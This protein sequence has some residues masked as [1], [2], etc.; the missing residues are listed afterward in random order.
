VPKQVILRGLG[1]S[2]VNAGVP[3]G[4][5]LNDPVLE[6]HGASGALITSNDNWKDS[7]ERA[8]FE[9]T[10]FQPT[11][12]RE[13]V[14]L[15]TLPPASYTAVLKGAANSTGV[16][17]VE[18]YDLDQSSDSTLTNI[19]SRALVETG[20]NVVIAGFTLG[21]PNGRPQIIIRGLGPSL[22]A[23][24]IANPLANPTL[25]LRDANAALLAANDNWKDDPFQSSQ[26]TAAGLQPQNDLESAIAAAL[27]PGAFTAIVAGKNGG[28]G[29]GLVEVYNL[30]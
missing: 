27:P 9:G 10:A 29:V 1:P 20:N 19:S 25:E 17:T 24:G 21:G 22:A 30:Q 6:L 12:D 5:V 11:D 3:A 18:V 28:T 7:P 8:Q 16:G 14:I 23:F 13:A 26:V 4:T 2:L 15:R